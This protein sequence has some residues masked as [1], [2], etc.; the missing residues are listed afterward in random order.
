[1]SAVP[2]IRALAFCALTPLAACA[3]NNEPPP[4]NEGAS[5]AATHVAFFDTVDNPEDDPGSERESRAMR[6]A[7]D[8]FQGLGLQ[9][10]VQ[11]VPLVRMIP[12]TATVTLSGP[13]G[14]VTEV[15]PSSRFIMWAGKQAERVTL[16][17]GIVFAG[18]GIVSPEYHRDDYKGAD[19][20]G[21][22]V[23]VLEGT[24]RTGTR[25]NLGTLGETYYGTRQYKFE[26]AARRGAAGVLIVHDEQEEPWAE[27]QRQA[28]GSIVD[29]DSSTLQHPQPK[30][31]IEGWLSPDTAR[32][33]LEMAGKNLPQFRH[34]AHEAAFEPVELPGVR[35]TV[36]M[37]SRLEKLTSQDVIAVLPGRHPE[38]VLL[39]GRWNRIDP[40]AWASRSFAEAEAGTASSFAAPPDTEMVSHLNDDGSGA[41]VVMEAA[42]R[43]VEARERPLRSVVFMVGTALK[44]GLLGLEYYV[45]HPAIRGSR[46]DAL[47]VMDRADLTGASQRLGKIGTASDT[48]LSQL[49]RGAAIEQGRLVELDENPHRR[50]YYKFGQAALARHGVRMIALTSTPEEDGASRHLRHIASRDRVVGFTDAGAHSFVP[51][52]RQDS[53]LLTALVRRVANAT[54]WPPHHEPAGPAR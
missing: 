33:L 45:E 51:N 54:N 28:T 2:A 15:S 46:V 26:E 14:V 22:I 53:A 38:H 9:T 49:T 31:D 41:A 19:L 42:R 10:M 21:K 29:I 43:L 27:M 7:A 34:Q 5:R 23:V 17:T 50:F 39:A 32:E 25:S 40:D 24:P 48:A 47:I 3:V 20:T 18:Y 37:D 1:M 16:D 13:G 35:A 6:Y 52:P 12:I 4:R 30:A 44:P 8:Y 11:T 36:R